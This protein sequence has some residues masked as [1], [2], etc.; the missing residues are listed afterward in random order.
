MALAEII[1]KGGSIPLIGSK[2]KK[3]II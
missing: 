3:M 1:G 2:I